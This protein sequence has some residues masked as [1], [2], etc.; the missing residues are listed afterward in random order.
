MDLFTFERKQFPWYRSMRA[1]QPVHYREQEECWEVFRYDDVLQVLSDHETFSSAFRSGDGVVRPNA[2]KAPTP[3]IASTIIALDPPRHDQLRGLVAHDFTPRTLARLTPRITQIANDLLDQV[4]PTG[5]MDVVRDF[6]YPLP[7][8]VIAEMLGL[9][10]DERSRFKWWSDTFLAGS[11]K[12]RIQARERGLHGTAEEARK[13]MSGYFEEMLEQRRRQPGDDLM[14]KLIAARVD[15][16]PLSQEELLGFCQLLLIAGNITTTNL[17]ANAIICFDEHPEA[18]ERLRQTP[19]TLPRAIEEV[20]RYRSPVHFLGRRTTTTTRLG[21][22]EI[23]AGQMILA[24]LASANRDEAQFPEPET[25]DIERAPNHHLSFGYDIH[26]CLGAHLARLEAKIGLAAM[27]ERLSDMRRIS[28]TPLEMVNS[29]II[30]GVK[31]L[32]L[33]FTPSAATAREPVM[34]G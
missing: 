19:Q 28:E 22:Q 5:S 23:Q 17:I 7:V 3:P 1:T 25:F 4:T 26:F 2:E 16:Q 18:L 8:M 20:L 29:D 30:Y 12:E 31:S 34:P 14:S 6:S 33:T 27:L 13:E 24:W 11:F 32:P 15:E 10:P 21:G 9:P